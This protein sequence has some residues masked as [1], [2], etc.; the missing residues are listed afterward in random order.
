MIAIGWVEGWGQLR[1]S[2]GKETDQRQGIKRGRQ[3]IKREW[4]ELYER[5]M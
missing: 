4:A 3:G 1:W 2:G 5:G